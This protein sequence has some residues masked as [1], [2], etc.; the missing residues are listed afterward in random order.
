MI[1][2]AND[3]ESQ[4]EDRCGAEGEDRPG[5]D[6]LLNWSSRRQV[7]RFEGETGRLEGERGLIEGQKGRFEGELG[8]RDI[9]NNF[10]LRGRFEGGI[11]TWFDSASAFL[12]F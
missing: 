9:E 8:S 12:P 3:E 1:D 5:G 10:S 7:E 4:T 2:G 6:P 11:G